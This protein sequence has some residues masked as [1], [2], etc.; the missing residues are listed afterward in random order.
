LGKS[1]HEKSEY[2]YATSIEFVHIHFLR[3][4]VTGIGLI[5]LKR[6]LVQVKSK[7]LGSFLKLFK[8]CLGSF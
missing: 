7:H 3:T 6:L 4:K 2:I 1:T 8:D 5:P